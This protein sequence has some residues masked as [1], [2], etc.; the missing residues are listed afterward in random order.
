MKILN[1]L[2]CCI[3]SCMSFATI[4]AT[5][6]QEEKEFV[7]SIS[8]SPRTDALS[9]KFSA[10]DTFDI[11]SIFIDEIP[12]G[13]LDYTYGWLAGYKN[14]NEFHSLNNFSLEFHYGGS[15]DGGCGAPT[16]NWGDTFAMNALP[17]IYQ[18]QYA[19]LGK[20]RLISWFNM[21][22]HLD[23][24]G[25][26]SF[27]E[28]TPKKQESMNASKIFQG[29]LVYEGSRGQAWLYIHKD[30]MALVLEFPSLDLLLEEE[31]EFSKDSS[32]MAF[33]QKTDS[34]MKILGV[35]YGADASEVAGTLSLS[36]PDKT[37]HSVAFIMS[38]FKD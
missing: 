6:S 25:F 13:G 1:I 28:A 2:F 26:V 36:F 29:E 21:N 33:K 5:A 9:F 22:T 12:M 38:E 24:N 23:H 32:H 3:L 31:V 15:S 17:L 10:T 11:D 27:G 7:G 16:D 35:F 4:G 19:S 30:R 37:R 8:F 20:W 34:Q 18:Y 14:R